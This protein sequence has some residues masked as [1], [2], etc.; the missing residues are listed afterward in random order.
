MRFILIAVYYV[1]EFAEE[2]QEEMW[3]GACK[4]VPLSYLSYLMSVK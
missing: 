2:S 4:R 1:D 3:G